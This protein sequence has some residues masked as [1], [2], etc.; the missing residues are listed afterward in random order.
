MS[1]L[2]IVFLVRSSLALIILLSVV[3]LAIE[4]QEQEE[5]GP[6]I[7]RGEEEHGH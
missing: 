4:V 7:E 5:V 1:G 2:V 3:C 6:D